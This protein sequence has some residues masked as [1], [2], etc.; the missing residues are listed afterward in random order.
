MCQG[1]G[2]ICCL[3]KTAWPPTSLLRSDCELTLLDSLN[4]RLIFLET[5][6]KETGVKAQL[7]HSRAEDG[8]QNPKLREQFDVATARAV[9]V[10]PLLCEYCLP[11]VKEG[12]RFIALK[13]PANDE[14]MG[15]AKKAMA[16]LGGKIQSKEKCVLPPDK[17]GE[18]GARQIVV[19]EKTAKT[20]PKYP[21]PAAKIAKNPL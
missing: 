15:R 1:V 2:L 17:N 12:G 14:E 6:C 11:F 19:I 13:G 18:Q 7:I 5:V 20:P 10:L 21:R 3:P 4:K 16:V 9:G 8:G